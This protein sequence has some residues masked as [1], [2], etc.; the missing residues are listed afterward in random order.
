MSA[1]EWCGGVTD[2]VPVLFELQGSVVN[3]ITVI[4]RNVTVRRFGVPDLGWHI[5]SKDSR[6]RD[7]GWK[8]SRVWGRRIVRV[9]R[10]V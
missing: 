6:T 10:G 2:G 1:S 8:V 5:D 4:Q 3:V 9:G 7:K